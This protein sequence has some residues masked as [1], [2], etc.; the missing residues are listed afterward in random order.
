MRW[1]PVELA[2]VRELL[3]ATD[4]LSCGE[5]DL[6]AL[7]RMA[8]A[9]AAVEG[10]LPPV[11]LVRHASGRVENCAVEPGTAAGSWRIIAPAFLVAGDALIVDRAGSYSLEW[12]E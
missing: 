11:V 3:A 9:R 10:V 7:D 8:A 6:A 2:A 1:E 5:S 12:F 4:G